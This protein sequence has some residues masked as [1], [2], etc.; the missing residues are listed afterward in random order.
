MINIL[1]L[2][3][4]KTTYIYT[5]I[6]TVI[7]TVIILFFS[8]YNYYNDCVNNKFLENGY[9]YV[10]S[11]NDY[12]EEIKKYDGIVSIQDG[13]LFK[14]NFEDE[15]MGLIPLAKDEKTEEESE[16]ECLLYWD[17]LL[18][19]SY[20]N[21]LVFDYDENLKKDEVIIYQD[22]NNHS[23]GNIEKII[24]NKISLYFQDELIN[25]KI[26]NV[27]N[28]NKRG[29]KISKE[30]FDE[31]LTKQALNVKIIIYIIILF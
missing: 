26:N 24:N 8:F 3:R 19:G 4:R 15:F 21:I 2:F 9:V 27:V 14:P 25:L 13:I 16:E 7:T 20:D 10:I 28:N 11:H 22:W 30:L 6:L 23:A 5:T 17:E 18:N 12:T 1:S 31:L 29:I